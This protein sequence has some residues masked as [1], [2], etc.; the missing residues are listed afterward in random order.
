MDGPENENQLK[1]VL[2]WSGATNAFVG[3]DKLLE[4]SAGDSGTSLTFHGDDWKRFTAA[5]TDSRFDPTEFQLVGGTERDFS[6]ML[7]SQFGPRSEDLANYGAVIELL[8]RVAADA[9]WQ[10]HVK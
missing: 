3:F 6:Q 5:G 2:G 10:H 7:P 1:Q 9:G 8:P 4:Q